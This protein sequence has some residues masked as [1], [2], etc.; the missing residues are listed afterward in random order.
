[1]SNCRCELGLDGLETEPETIDEPL[2][3]NVFRCTICGGIVDRYEHCFRCQDCGALGDLVTGIMTD[4]S[5]K[6]EGNG[7]A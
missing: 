5:Y 1:M 2:A 3:R 4:C 7:Q 6:E